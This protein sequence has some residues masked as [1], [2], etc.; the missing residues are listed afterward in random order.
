MHI[1]RVINRMICTIHNGGV[2]GRTSHNDGD[3][4]AECTAITRARP[5][6]ARALLAMALQYPCWSV[7]RAFLATR[8][9]LTP[10]SQA[11]LRRHLETRVS[12]SALALFDPSTCPLRRAVASD[13]MGE[14][15]FLLRARGVSPP[16]W[17]AP[18]EHALLDP[19]G[20]LSAAR[21]EDPWTV[22]LAFLLVRRLVLRA[23]GD[24]GHVIWSF[25]KKR[26]YWVY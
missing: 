12:R 5:L 22:P 19:R 26:S 21:R 9:T 18:R 2:D 10:E 11:H 25:A 20:M 24:V 7:L 8:M 6:A 3:L 4:V 23:W 17:F 15:R 16:V 14:V 13:Q 1:R